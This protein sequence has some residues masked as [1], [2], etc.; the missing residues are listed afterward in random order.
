MG[1]LPMDKGNALGPKSRPKK[2]WQ[3]DLIVAL[4]VVFILFVAASSIPVFDGPNSR[5]TAHEAIAVGNLRK[6]ANLETNYSAAHT[7]QGFVCQM[8]LLKSTP[9]SSGEYDPEEFLI[10]DRYAGYK[11]KLDGCEPDPNG[12]VTHYRAAAVPAEPG[13]SGVRAFCTDQ[14]GALWYDNSGSADNCLARRKPIE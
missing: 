14:S 11:I 8:S 10:L 6:L 4:V 12:L 3:K 2:R 9:P 7:E 5:R 13:K 1:H